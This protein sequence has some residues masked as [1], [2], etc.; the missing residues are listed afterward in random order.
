MA[1]IVMTKLGFYFSSLPREV[2][3]FANVDVTTQYPE[4]DDS[5]YMA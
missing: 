3:L 2:E 4:D 5:R 1:E